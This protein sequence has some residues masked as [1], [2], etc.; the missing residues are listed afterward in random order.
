MMRPE[1]F[2]TVGLLVLALQPWCIAGE[3][4]IIAADHESVRRRLGKEADLL[5]AGPYTLLG[6]N[7]LDRNIVIRQTIIGDEQYAYVLNPA[8]WPVTVS[9]ALDCVAVVD[10]VETGKTISLDLAA[11]QTAILRLRPPAAF[12]SAE[13]RTPE[14]VVNEITRELTDLTLIL[15]HLP[16]RRPHLIVK[17]PGFEKYDVHKIPLNWRIFDWHKKDSAFGF[18][19]GNKTEGKQ[20][21][22]L[23]NAEHGK[24]IGIASDKF[25][26]HPGRACEL[27]V[28]LATSAPAPDGKAE[29]KAR[30]G[31]TGAQHVTETV[32]PDNTWR[33]FTLALSPAQ[34]E[35]V[36]P[37]GEARVEIHHDAKG[38]LWVDN[39]RVVD[40]AICD[41]ET[42]EKI[43]RLAD[44]LTKL[45][46]EK[47]FVG[48]FQTLQEGPVRELLRKVAKMKIGNEWLIVGPFPAPSDADMLKACPPEKDVLEGKDLRDAEYA[49]SEGL[50]VR[51]V[52]NWTTPAAGG[53]GR[54]DLCAAVGPFDK[55]TAYAYTE[56]ESGLNRKAF[57]L[58]G[59]DDA[60]AV[61]VNGKPASLSPVGAAG[62]PG[63]DVAAADLVRGWNKILLKIRNDEKLWDFSLSIVDENGNPIKDIR[64]GENIL[65][66]KKEAAK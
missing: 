50:K 23:D 45:F 37:G 38:I 41:I 33:Q 12:L 14:A 2:L 54:M 35:R 44:L 5:P 57:L 7:G 52:T 48:C 58:I 42:A 34:T 51:W 55:T 22:F 66:R 47:D 32:R 26:I 4:T 20:A 29:G 64:Y 30:I 46:S 39:V 21:F 49:G 36:A 17:N 62:A 15:P 61:W 3:R 59:R 19:L 53:A 18:D 65:V 27:A 6:G 1:R 9:I 63:E 10:G 13:T 40:S 31:F 11:Y 56:V 60:V 28:H 16:T 43:E 25:R 24:T 8:W